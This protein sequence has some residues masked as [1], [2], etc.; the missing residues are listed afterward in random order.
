MFDRSASLSGGSNRLAQ[1][2]ADP[3]HWPTR[4]WTEVTGLKPEGQDPHQ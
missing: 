4:S 1:S 3:H 2:V